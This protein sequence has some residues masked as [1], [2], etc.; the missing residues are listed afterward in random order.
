MPAAAE[1]EGGVR[2][3]VLLVDDDAS[4]RLVLATLLEDEGFQVEEAASFAEAGQK[5]AAEGA[6][7]DLALLDQNLGDGHGTDLVA[8][9]RA[10][11]PRAKAVLI[12]GSGGEDLGDAP[13]PDA[14]IS[15]GIGFPDLLDQIRQLL[16]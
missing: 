9:L 11:L 8:V 3:T 4:S 6:R 16:G 13:P 7:Y 10:R 1:E 14:V 5:L 2:V 15:K 12:S